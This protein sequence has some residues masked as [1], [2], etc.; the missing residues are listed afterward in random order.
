VRI[1]VDTS[2]F[3][4]LLASDDRRHEE[5]RA[6]WSRLV[7]DDDHL[8]TT[9]YALIETVAIV[10]RRLGL[11]AVRALNDELLPVVSVEWVGED[12]H[13]ASMAALVTAG[14]G[15]LSLVDCVS[16]EI[17]RRQGVE[18]AFTFDGDFAAQGFLPA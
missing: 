3:L 11:A 12:L 8:F 17:M 18:H 2:A 7:A 14:R 10:Q 5:A 6:V 1:L 15:R 9:S 13:R 4:A 16:F